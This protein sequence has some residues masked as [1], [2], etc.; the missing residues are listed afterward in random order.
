MNRL[1]RGLVAG[2]AAVPL[3]ALSLP[4]APPENADPNLA[5]WFRGLTQPGSGASCCDLSD[6]R[7]ASTRIGP[8]GYEVL[9]AEST[10]PVAAD[11]WV[12]VPPERIL[13]GKD[14]PLGRGVVC[15]TPNKGVICF[16]RPSEA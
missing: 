1:L 2:L 8:D 7:G 11:Q 3:Y 5:Q 12:R 16:V 13:H 4:A 10:F 9:I 14:N 15:W 6:C